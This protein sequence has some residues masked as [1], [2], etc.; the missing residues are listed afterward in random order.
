MTDTKT[1][2]QSIEEIRGRLDT[3]DI[4]LEN[5]NKIE[6]IIKNGEEKHITYRRNEFFQMLNDR[7]NVW[8]DKARLGLKD[9][10]LFGGVT[11][12][13]LKDIFGLL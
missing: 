9:I 13:I 3:I 1:T 6:I 4:H 8:K 10:L 2:K 7:K 11:L 5:L 12:L